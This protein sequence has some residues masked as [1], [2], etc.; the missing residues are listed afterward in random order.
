[1]DKI[2]EIKAAVMAEVAEYYATR[3]ECGAGHA[4]TLEQRAKASGMLE[5]LGMLTGKRYMLMHDGLQEV[6]NND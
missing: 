1:M 2:A 4:A 3:K 5:V 6:N